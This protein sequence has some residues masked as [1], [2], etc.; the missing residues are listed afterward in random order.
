MID[1][2]VQDVIEAIRVA[3][4]GGRGIV[5]LLGSGFSAEAGVPTMDGLIR[6]LAQLS[7][8]VEEGAYLP[9]LLRNPEKSQAFS[10]A[11]G[12][13]NEKSDLYREDLSRF[14]RDHGWPDSYQL[15]QEYGDRLAGHTPRADLNEQVASRLEEVARTLYP[16]RASLI[17]DTS[18]D[19]AGE[20]IGGLS[21]RIQ[22]S[23]LWKLVGRWPDLVQYATGGHVGYASRLFEQLRQRHHPGLSHHFLAFLTR[24]LGI[25]L[26]LTSA[27]DNLLEAALTAEQIE[28]SVFVME[29]G[30][31]FP[32]PGLVR[33]VTAVVRMDGDLSRLVG[34]PMF[35]PMDEPSLSQFSDSLP[36]NPLLLV[37]GTSGRDRRVFD[38]VR[39]LI[40][41]E[42]SGRPAGDPA[43]IWLH[44]EGIPPNSLTRLL[45]QDDARIKFARVTHPGLFLTHL[46]SSLTSR[47]PSSSRPYLAHPERPIGLELRHA[48][49]EAEMDDATSGVR[50]F[51]KGEVCYLF[52]SQTRDER[53]K[54]RPTDPNASERLAAFINELPTHIPL[55]IDLEGQLTL[56]GV[57]GAIIDQCRTYDPLLTPAILP[58]G[59]EGEDAIGKG[60]SRVS[61]ALSRARYALAIDG[62]E[63]YTWRHTVHHGDIK[64]AGASDRSH[65][66]GDSEP[67][68]TRDRREPLLKFLKALIGNAENLNGSLIGIAIGQPAL[69]RSEDGPSPAEEELRSVEN[70][71]KRAMVVD[72]QES[73]IF[74]H[75]PHDLDPLDRSLL[76]Q[77][78]GLEHV[79]V[80]PELD[81]SE[82]FKWTCP[83]ADLL[84]LFCLSCF[85]RTRN[86]VALRSILNPLIDRQGM[87]PEAAHYRADPVLDRFHESGFLLSVGGGAFWMRRL[88]RDDVY[89]TN[90]RRTKTEEIKKLASEL[91][92]TA[93]VD[94]AMRPRLVHPTIQCLL[95]AFLHDR[96]A[97]YY[98]FDNYI[99]SRDPFAFFEYVYHR[100]SSIRY[101]NKLVILQ[102]IITERSADEW[103]R[104]GHA[105]SNAL[106][107]VPTDF[108]DVP[109]S[110]EGATGLRGEIMALLDPGNDLRSGRGLQRRRLREIRSLRLAWRRCRDPLL[111][112]VPA[113]QLISWCRWLIEDDLK[114]FLAGTYGKEIGVEV[115]AIQ[116][117]DDVVRDETDELERE[118]YDLCARSYI[119][120]SDY[121]KCIKL[122]LSQLLSLT[123]G[124]GRGDRGDGMDGNPGIHDDFEDY[125]ARLDRPNESRPWDELLPGEDD[126]DDRHDR[127]LLAC[128]WWLDIAECLSAKGERKS[129]EE[130]LPSPDTIT[131]TVQLLD[132]LEK[133]LER[134]D[135]LPVHGPE[136]GMGVK[137]LRF[138]GRALLA[139]HWLGMLTFRGSGDLFASRYA[140]EIGEKIHKTC[141]NA[142]VDLRQY[143]SEDGRGY[144]ELRAQFLIVRARVQPLLQPVPSFDEA[145]RDLELARGGPSPS[146]QLLLARADLF[147]A[148]LALIEADEKLAFSAGLRKGRGAES[149]DLLKSSKLLG[150]AAAKH[151]LARGYLRRLPRHLLAG[152][153]NTV[154]WRRYF[155][156]L[157]KYLSERNL[158]ILARAVTRRALSPNSPGLRGRE[159]AGFVR[160]LRL[161]LHAIRRGLDR[162]LE[163]VPLDPW[164]L[165]T[166]RELFFGS[167]VFGCLAEDGARKPGEGRIDLD[168]QLQLALS[169]GGELVLQAWWSLNRSSGLLVGGDWDYNY[170][171]QNR[172]QND[173]MPSGKGS[174]H[175]LRKLGMTGARGLLASPTLPGGLPGLSSALSEKALERGGLPLRLI[176]VEL[177]ANTEL[178]TPILSFK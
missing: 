99:Q 35:Q 74:P 146:D 9:P 5:P 29:G 95:L 51:R 61:D 55:W 105:C 148:E 31:Q 16:E 102:A 149:A 100:V 129:F 58:L 11:L 172:D 107:E 176:I 162:N 115:A 144:L 131:P 13:L 177:A 170:N 153:R 18:D 62:L 155:Q 160:K 106:A 7:G 84:A 124:P 24:V 98:Y 19:H 130:A 169:S 2:P 21:P 86:L 68:T 164:L 80:R 173:A 54:T 44:Y 92:A 32:A 122:R 65:F 1:Q 26:F 50:V 75:S 36:E 145:Y 135:D 101:L 158:W 141:R 40:K 45:D 33:D 110:G 157:A 142:L 4:R 41:S 14:V 69:R 12:V 166:W 119:E 79:L 66:R 167:L 121:D 93:T 109:K 174:I 94:S 90:S 56:A 175:D 151:G 118:L 71:L 76:F 126:H 96:I 120:R 39:R 112:S 27:V 91:R 67:R 128:G 48:A 46:Y 77:G 165:Q 138:R 59:D 111:R 171:I 70:D 147:A 133:L 108:F 117:L 136:G 15:Y 57:V 20:Q 73:R 81:A 123:R 6:Y 140:R 8:Y 60:V 25:R 37:M 42:R 132:R 83:N 10:R 82:A 17:P 134:L 143:D 156:L 114:R 34:A 63:C 154:W 127:L 125:F 104:V 28:Y 47:H 103:I 178:E 53:R 113:E 78:E 88:L 43:V 38:I 3:W 159:V 89:S 161:A 52:S 116:G 22:Q 168:E 87:A 30:R 72:E 152:R 137:A 163:S 64:E 49:P 150:E 139:E 85:R 23:A 97:R